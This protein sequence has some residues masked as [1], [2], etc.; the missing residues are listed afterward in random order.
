MLALRRWRR[1]PRLPRDRGRRALV[2]RERTR[3]GGVSEPTQ[4]Q[5]LQ[6]EEE[7]DFLLRSLDDLE[8]E[9][10]AGNIDDETYAGCTTTTP[11]G[12]RRRCGPCATASSARPLVRRRRQRTG[13]SSS[14]GWSCSRSWR[15]SP[16]RSRSAPASRARRHRQLARSTV[17]ARRD[18]LEATVREQPGRRRGPPRARP[19]PRAPGRD[20]RR[21]EVVRR[22][23]AHRARERR[24]V[25][26]PGGSATSSPVSCRARGARAVRRDG[27]VPA[28]PAV[29]VAPDYP[30][31]TS[32]G[33]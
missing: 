30:T 6:L 23:R 18:R 14:A 5:P 21:A 17:D 28:R 29:T 4:E 22:R 31:P 19:L 25:R 3:S 11:P 26:L 13:C 9:R 7:R 27:P 1:E 12:P 32:S 16:W 24:R 8:A 15:R 33:A 20:P 2:A 10:A